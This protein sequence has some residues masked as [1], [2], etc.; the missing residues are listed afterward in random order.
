MPIREAAKRPA[1][2]STSFESSLESFNALRKARRFSA[3]TIRK[4]AL[5]LSRL[6][7]F[8]R[9]RGLSNIME[10]K[11]EDLVAYARH[12][13]ERKPPL[14]PWSQRAYLSQII[15]FFASLDR[16]GVILQNPALDLVM[17]KVSKIPRNILSETQAGKMMEQPSPW[18]PQGKRDRAIMELLYGA[19]LR[20]SEC[21]KLELKDLDLMKGSLFV[22]QGKG[23]KDRVVPIS[24]RASA[25]VD[26]YLKEGR[27]GLVRSP[28]QQALFL[29]ASGTPVE[30]STIQAVVRGAAKA[31]GIPFVVTSHTLRHTCATHLLRNGADIA[32]VQKLLGHAHISTTA[33]YTRVFPKDLAAVMKRAHPRERT[34]NRHRKRTL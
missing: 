1:A 4:T 19:G 18:T 17:P 25:A 7:V 32:H 26:L 27:P 22:H 33:I 16:L 23:K 30:A 24:G 28:R 13:A 8:L 14:A 15:A 29:K 5:V 3:V 10:V 6:F 34:Y 31:A 20:V 9:Q 11:E 2:L 12:L 21:A